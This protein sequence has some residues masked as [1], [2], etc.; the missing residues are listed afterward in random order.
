L[1]FTSG[2]RPRIEDHQNPTILFRT[3]QRRENIS[4]IYSLLGM[5]WYSQGKNS[6]SHIILLWRLNSIGFCLS[7]ENLLKMSIGPASFQSL[8]GLCRI[9]MEWIEGRVKNS[10]R[11]FSFSTITLGQRSTN[12][13]G[14]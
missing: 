8:I 7:C 1:S 11:K 14:D 4:V 12:D 6:P 13:I 10:K 5:Q 3:N 9:P 2:L